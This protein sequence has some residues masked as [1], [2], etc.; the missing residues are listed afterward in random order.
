MYHLLFA[1]VE[2]SANPW[3]KSHVIMVYDLFNVLLDTIGGILLRI[4]ASILISVIGL[5]FSFFV[6]SLSGFCSRMM[7]AL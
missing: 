3:A 1:D 7:V 5:K 2:K 6:L 4:F